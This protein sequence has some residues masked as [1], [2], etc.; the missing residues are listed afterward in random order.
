MSKKI[1]KIK[2]AAIKFLTGTPEIR[3]EKCTQGINEICKHF[4]CVL[5]PSITTQG[6]DLTGYRVIGDVGVMPIKEEPRIVTPTG[7]PTVH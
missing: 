1:I 7:K 2:R 3:V 5:V 4:E 6:N